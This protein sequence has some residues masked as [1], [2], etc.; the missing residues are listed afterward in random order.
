MATERALGSGLACAV[1]ATDDWE[2]KGDSEG[3]PAGSGLCCTI[4]LDWQNEP[5][6]LQHGFVCYALYRA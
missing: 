6:A 2:N 1:L 4:S 5:S 3:Q